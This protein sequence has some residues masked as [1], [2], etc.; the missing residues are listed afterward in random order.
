MLFAGITGW[1][2]VTSSKIQ[3]VESWI[4]D[5]TVQEE[6]QEA[7]SR[8]LYS[9]SLSQA[10]RQVDRMEKNLSTY[11]KLTDSVIREIEDVSGRDMDVRIQGLD[12]ATGTLSFDAVSRQ[13]IDIPGYVS[14]LKDTGLFEEVNYTGYT[15]GDSE[16]TLSLSC[17]LK[18]A[19]DGEVE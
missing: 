5:D 9:A 3:K 16:Y 7:E 2:A 17:I 10:I 19:T 11:P 6:Y 8:K 13:V 18:E 15:Y 12:I 4:E 1:N 14:R